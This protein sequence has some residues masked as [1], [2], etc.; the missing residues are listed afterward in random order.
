M[1]RRLG[2]AGWLVVALVA[3]APALAHSLSLTL[4]PSSDPEAVLRCAVHLDAGRMRVVQG[5]GPGA[6]ERVVIWTPTAV[7]QAVM[8]SALAAFVAGDLPSVLPTDPAQP[9]PPFVTVN[10]I[11]RLDGGILAGRMVAPG[12][13]LPPVLKAVVVRLMPGS[14]CDRD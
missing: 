6:G 13:D 14:L 2:A 4:W 5:R 8:M 9:A 3:P 11:T 12:L 7:E 1:G 10:W